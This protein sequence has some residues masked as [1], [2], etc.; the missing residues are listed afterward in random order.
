[1]R[2]NSLTSLKLFF[3]RINCCVACN[4]MTIVKT[5]DTSSVVE[6]RETNKWTTSHSS[7]ITTPR[8]TKVTSSTA[9]FIE[10]T[11]LIPIHA[12]FIIHVSLTTA[13]PEL[14]LHSLTLLL[15]FSH[16]TLT[17]CW[18]NINNQI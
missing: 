14:F 2:D 5:F 10:S 12:F 15:A 8:L 18:L 9:F 11:L 13:I 7:K 3:L 1:M 16:F 17:Q 6:H 4:D